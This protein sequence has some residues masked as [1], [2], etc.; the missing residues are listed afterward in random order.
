MEWPCCVPSSKTFHIFQPKVGNVPGQ[1]IP[2]SFIDLMKRMLQLDSN[3]RITPRALL[4]HPFIS[5]LERGVHHTS[6]CPESSGDHHSSSCPEPS[7]DHYT[8]CC[9][10]PS[11]DH[12]TRCCSWAQWGPLHPLLLWAQWGPLHPLLPDP[13]V[14]HYTRCCSEPSG[15]HYTRCLW[16]QWGPLH[17]L[18][19]T[20]AQWGPLQQLPWA[21]C[22]PPQQRHLGEAE[23]TVST[24]EP[25]TFCVRGPE[26]HSRHH[27]QW[28][29]VCVPFTL[30]CFLDPL[31][32]WFLIF[33][34]Q[35]SFPTGPVLTP[36]H[37]RTGLTF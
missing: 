4:E 5:S 27:R 25:H 20:W 30:Q 1:P 8:R 32:S 35:H 36:V 23:K 14:D 18:L 33:C 15:G 29:R 2:P 22:G 10:E 3:Q 9:S 11:G 24:C 34:V 37:S 21:H 16:A 13:S 12:Y 19:W 26:G 28:Q 31:M 7:G 17:P 6:C